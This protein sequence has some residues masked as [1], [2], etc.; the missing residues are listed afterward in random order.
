V[1][2]CTMDVAWMLQG[3]RVHHM[4]GVAGNARP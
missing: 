1:A 2:V 4:D 3:G